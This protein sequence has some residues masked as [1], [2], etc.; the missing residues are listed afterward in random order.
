MPT[1][2]SLMGAPSALSPECEVIARCSGFSL[3]ARCAV[4]RVCRVL[5]HVE[6]SPGF[7]VLNL[8]DNEAYAQGVP[9]ECR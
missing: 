7:G 6:Q 3:K 9:E 4:R 5:V 8:V 1:W 2:S